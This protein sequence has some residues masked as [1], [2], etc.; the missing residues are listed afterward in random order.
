MKICE[1]AHGGDLLIKTIYLEIDQKR[2][3]TSRCRVTKRP[4]AGNAAAAAAAAAAE[5]R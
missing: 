1:R 2:L 4:A 5:S 3:E